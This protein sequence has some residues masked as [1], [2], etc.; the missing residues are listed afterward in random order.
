MKK[1]AKLI[2]KLLTAAYKSKVVRFKLDKDPLNFRVY[3]LS[4][5]NS[6]KIALSK[7]SETYMLIADYPF[8]RGE[9][10]PD[11]AKKATCNLLHVYIYAHSQI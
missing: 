10:I 4:L 7:F 3:F 11:Y 2:A 1:R 5:L 9:E 8:I 6:L